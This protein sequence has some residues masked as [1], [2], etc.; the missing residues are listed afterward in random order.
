MSEF[1]FVTD[2]QSQVVQAKRVGRKEGLE[3][4]LEKGRNELLDLLKNG[5]SPDEIMRLYNKK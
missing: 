3:E 2:T 4:G 1:K 5:T